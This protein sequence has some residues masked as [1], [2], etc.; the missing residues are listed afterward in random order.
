M[1]VRPAATKKRWLVLGLALHAVAATVL[2]TNALC[3]SAERAA[4]ARAPARAAP[5]QTAL[6][7]LAGTASAGRSEDADRKALRARVTGV[8]EALARAL[9][10]EDYEDVRWRAD[11]AEEARGLGKD[12]LPALRALLAEEQRSVEEHAAATELVAALEQR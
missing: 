12:A 3:S 10:S 2:T 1:T 7:D 9:E 11:V 5:S 8:T 6:P 4:P